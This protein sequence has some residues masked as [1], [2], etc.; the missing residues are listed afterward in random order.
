[1]S[2]GRAPG[3][4]TEEPDGGPGQSVA[5]TPP[6]P[7]S[8]YR[9]FAVAIVVAVAV[10]TV[11]V[12]ESTGWSFFHPGAAGSGPFPSQTCVG[13]PYF[14]S[15]YLTAVVSSG[16]GLGWSSAFQELGGSFSNWSGLC[17]HVNVSVSTG[18]GYVPDLAA[19]GPFFAVS[20]APP[21][22]TDRAVLGARVT[23]LPAL[24]AAVDIV[25]N[26]AGL[27]SNLRLSGSVLAGIYEGTITSW[28]SPRIAELNPG[29]DLPTTPAIV[30]VYRSAATNSNL[31][32]T[33]FLAESNVTWNRTVG[34]GASVSWP[35]GVGTTGPVAMANEIASTPGAVGYL[36]GLDAR[37]AGVLNATLLNPAGAYVAPTPENTTD[38]AAGVAGLPAVADLNWSNLTSGIS[39]VDAPGTGSY[40]VVELA[41]VSLYQDLGKA[42]AGTLS[43]PNASWLLTYLWWSVSDAAT[44]E[45]SLGLA[46]L[47]S[48]FEGLAQR[49]LATE[50]YDGTLLI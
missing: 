18:D 48:S 29:V 3:P 23:V 7:G 47:P 31:A 42:Y 40:P 50:A 12:G 36:E 16:S 2:A 9:W 5:P 37:T 25:Y 35:T 22:L 46:P 24:L 10:S 8:R 49:L 4:E 21:N 6:Q 17:A 43:A 13:V 44:S 14:A 33:T 1:M 34:D 27:P 32:F 45:R 11:A 30:P 28:A 38:A 19:K 20:G 41:Y 39:F 26:A 15:A